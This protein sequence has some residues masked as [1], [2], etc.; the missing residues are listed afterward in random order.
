MRRSVASIVEEAAAARA[1]LAEITGGEP[2]LQEGFGA[3]ATALR[4]NSGKPVLVETNGS[5]DISTVPQGVIAV[6]DVKC[7]GSGEAASFDRQNLLRLRAY[8]EVKFVIS[9]RTDYEWARAL[10]S[11]HA[12]PRKCH[13]LHF[14]PVHP[15]LNA[16]DLAEWIVEDRLEVRLQPQLHR[17]LNVR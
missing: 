15:T 2:L 14:S 13:A 5:L 7:P 8:D 9:D 6:M 11:S 16:R 1:P 12:L 4:D 10:V 17:L 3:L